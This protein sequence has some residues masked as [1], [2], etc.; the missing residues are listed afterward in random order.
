MSLVVAAVTTALVALFLTPLFQEL[1]EAALGAIV[2]VA[3]SEMERIAPLRRL[4]RIRRADFVVALIALLGVLVVGI[5]PGLAL[6]VLVSLG[7]IVWRA[8]EGHLEVVG[9]AAGEETGAAETRAAGGL[10]VVR[11][12]QM[13]FFANADEIRDAVG[14]ALSAAAAPPDTVVLDLGLTPD[15]DVP[16]LDV[17]V[18]LRE[19]LAVDGTRLWLV[20][21]IARVIARL[22]RAGVVDPSHDDVFRDVTGAMVGYVAAHSSAAGR[23]RETVLAEVR[24]IIRE[25]REDPATDANARAV[26]DGIEQRLTDAIGDS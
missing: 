10:L 5:L 8:G 25:R 20:T 24:A 26:L 22:D 23:S 1:P 4:W 16:S 21:R 14:A 6:A 12:L 18:A 7:L 9:A 11:P 13:L 19:R 2:I 3:V 17:L 15:L